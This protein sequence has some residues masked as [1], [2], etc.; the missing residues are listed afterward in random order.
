ME[1]RETYR[2]YGS[3]SHQQGIAL[4]LKDILPAVW[5][6][7]AALFVEIVFVNLLPIHYKKH[8]LLILFAVWLLAF[9]A[10]AS[11]KKDSGFVADDTCV[12][13]SRKF[14]KDVAIPYFDIDTIAVWTERKSGNG[15]S[16][17]F[18]VES[19]LI[20][21][22]DGQDYEF[23]AVMDIKPNGRLEATGFMDKMLEMGKF[24]VLQRY[25]EQKKQK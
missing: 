7:A 18:Y 19:I 24:K 15:K 22:L 13:F 5:I 23:K 16:G 9:I 6:N 4:S 11:Y 20:T 12:T 3:P 14:A 2:S 21:T 1:M 17:S 8:L 10:Y 25:I